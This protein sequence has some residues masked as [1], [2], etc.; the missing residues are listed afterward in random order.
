MASYPYR[1]L[2]YDSVTFASI[3]FLELLCLNRKFVARFHKFRNFLPFSSLSSHQVFILFLSWSN[4]SQEIKWNYR[5]KTLV[6]KS[7]V[8]PRL[9]DLP[10][11]HTALDLIPKSS[12]TKR[13]KLRLYLAYLDYS[14][15]MIFPVGTFISNAVTYVLVPLYLISKN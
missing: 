9:G 5:E 1:D 8:E 11:L 4:R 15:S 12:D 13:L 3:N 7:R 2:A 14:W 6:S 10:R